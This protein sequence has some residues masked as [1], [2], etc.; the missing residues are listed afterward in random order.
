MDSSI[1]NDEINRFVALDHARTLGQVKAM[2]NII[3][4]HECPFCIQNLHKEHSNPILKENVYWFITENQWPYEG[5]EKHLLLIS[6]SHYENL[7]DV[8]IE[9]FTELGEMLHWID[10][11]FPSTGG[12]IGMRFGDP[13]M[14]GATVRHIHIHFVV[15]KKISDPGFTDVKFRMSGKS[16][17]I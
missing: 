3:S 7:S 2:E 4:R 17:K 6:R 1:N 8:P 10:E 9:A 15:P 14:T 12:A 5:S 11:H 13:A 16:K